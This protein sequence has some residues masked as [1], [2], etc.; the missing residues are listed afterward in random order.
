ML[1]GV[2]LWFDEAD[3]GAAGYAVILSDDGV[4]PSA[5][6]DL[7]TGRRRS[8]PPGPAHGTSLNVPRADL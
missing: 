2:H 5:G 4:F 8:G 6:N 3:S 7:A 1:R